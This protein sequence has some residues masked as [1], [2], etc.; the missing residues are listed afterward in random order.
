M[1]TWIVPSFPMAPARPLLS[2]LLLSDTISSLDLPPKYTVS[3][4]FHDIEILVYWAQ[5]QEVLHRPAVVL[6]TWTYLW[7]GGIFSYGEWIC[8]LAICSILFS[9]TP[10]PSPS[11]VSTL[12]NTQKFD[13]FL[14]IQWSSWSCLAEFSAWDP[15]YFAFFLLMV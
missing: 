10:S 3:F 8:R 12:P 9:K 15:M 6:V 1:E 13:L 11:P 7:F 14:S 5:D 2:D 4:F